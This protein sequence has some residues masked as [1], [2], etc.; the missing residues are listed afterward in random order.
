MPEFTKAMQFV[1]L[2]SQAEAKAAH[3]EEATVEFLFLGLLK[4]AEVRAA[5]F[6]NASSS[7]SLKA[8]DD[9]IKTV[10][11]EFEKHGIDTSRARGLLRYAVHQGT[12][13]TGRDL[14]NRLARA[15]ELAAKRKNNTISA[16]DLL[17]S[18]LESPTDLILQ[19]CPLKK[20]E[21][22]PIVQ[23]NEQDKKEEQGRNVS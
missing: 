7:D 20:K 3:Q 1:L 17:V 12:L 13:S 4:L 21:E 16:P 9:E 15:A 5:D 10:R 11:A 23:E 22:K 6:V 8:V 19:I 2:R 14:A 18:I